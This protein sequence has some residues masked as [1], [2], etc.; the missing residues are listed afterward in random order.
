MTIITKKVR[1]APTPFIGTVLTIRVDENRTF[2]IRSALCAAGCGPVVVDWGDGTIEEFDG[3]LAGVEHNYSN[4]GT[5]DIRLSDDLTQMFLSDSTDTSSYSAVYAPMVRGFRTNA[6]R[7]NV[8]QAYQFHNCANLV[9]FDVVDGAIK[10]I[11]G[12]AFKNCSSL[13][14]LLLPHVVNVSSTA[15]SLPF[16][17]CSSLASIHF[18]SENKEKIK[19]GSAYGFDPT[20]GTGVKDVCHFDL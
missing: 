5:Y 4:S 16:A 2:G 18:A 10:A 12:G 14:R 19:S 9:C 20:L 11:A 3:N 13:E 15:S 17:G 6:T 1:L 7:L 8:I